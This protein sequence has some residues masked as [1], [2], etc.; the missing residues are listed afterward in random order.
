MVFKR[1]QKPVQG[2]F[3]LHG[4]FHLESFFS[5]VHALCLSAV[6][7]GMGL[8]TRARARVLSVRAY[9][10]GVLDFSLLDHCLTIPG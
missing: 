10:R 4:R 1:S 8:A 6:K 9:R 2:F 5:N 3:H 7:A